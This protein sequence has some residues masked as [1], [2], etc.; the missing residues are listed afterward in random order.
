MRDEAR[1]FPLPIQ[2]ILSLC[3]IPRHLRELFVPDK[4]EAS[5]TGQT[6]RDLELA[7]GLAVGLVHGLGK[8]FTG[9]TGGLW[10]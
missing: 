5:E 2:S 4:S 10:S 7:A 9:R 1:A 3:I 6:N 8:H